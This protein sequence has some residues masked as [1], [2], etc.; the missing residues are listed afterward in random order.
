MSWPTVASTDVADLWRPLTDEETARATARIKIVEAELRAELRLHG[1]TGTPSV[2]DPGF[3]TQE[4]VEEWEDLYKGIVAGAVLAAV[5][6]PEGWL[7][8]RVAIDDFSE[9]RRRDSATSTGAVIVSD[10]DVR[11][12]LPRRVRPRDSF[13]I[14][15]GAT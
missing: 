3:E 4:Q 9:S 12:L 5:Q 6:N 11:R 15:L 8:E 2:G 7:E 13:T 10:V 1:L 14:R